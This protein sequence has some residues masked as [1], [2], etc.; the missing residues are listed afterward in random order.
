MTAK[1]KA[2]IREGIMKKLEN[3]SNKEKN[4]IKSLVD[5]LD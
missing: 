1:E 5:L 4:R 2:E 3:M